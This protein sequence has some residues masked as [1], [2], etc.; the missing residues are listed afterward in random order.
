[1]LRVVEKNLACLENAEVPV[2]HPIDQEYEET[3][4]TSERVFPGLVFRLKPQENRFS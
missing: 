3:E 1:M 2:D 4:T